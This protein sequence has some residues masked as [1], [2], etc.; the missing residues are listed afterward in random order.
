MN[1]SSVRPC[2]QPPTEPASTSISTTAEPATITASSSFAPAA[3]AAA[4][5]AA[6]SRLR[7]ARIHGAGGCQRGCHVLSFCIHYGGAVQV[8]MALTPD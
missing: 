1:S 3:V 7:P 4:A 5:V 2:S 8:D 6:A